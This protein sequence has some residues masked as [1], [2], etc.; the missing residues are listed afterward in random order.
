MAFVKSTMKK[1]SK[2]TARSVVASVAASTDR[3]IQR[4]QQAI[5]S[6]M[7]VMA[8]LEAK[9]AHRTKAREI[10]GSILSDLYGTTLNL[11]NDEHLEPVI[12]LHPRIH[13]GNIQK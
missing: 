1:F 3:T 10:M 13:G 9:A 8:D 4:K 12:L 7:A 6:K 5:A 11:R 2:A